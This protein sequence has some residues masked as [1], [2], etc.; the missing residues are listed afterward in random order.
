[1]DTTQSPN[2]GGGGFFRYTIT[3]LFNNHRF[4]LVQGREYVGD[5]LADRE[6]PK[7]VGLIHVTDPRQMQ[8]IQKYMPPTPPGRG[9]IQL[10]PRVVFRM[11]DNEEIIDIYP[12]F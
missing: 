6:F 3:L 12:D 4:W 1:M 9:M 8:V 5:I 7:P 11:R 2:G 10:N